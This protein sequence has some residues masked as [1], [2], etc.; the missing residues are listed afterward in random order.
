MRIYDQHL[1]SNHSFDSSAEPAEVCAAAIERGLAGITFT[2]HFDTHPTEWDDCR[3][4]YAAIAAEHARL[5]ERFG[6]RLTVGTGIEVCYQPARMDFILN[7]LG[8]R[9]F[10]L[11]ILSVHWTPC[12][13]IHRK[14][15][16]QG[17]SPEQ[18]TRQYLE[19]VLNAVRYCAQLKKNNASP[20]HVLGHLDFVKR[21]THRWWA[22]NRIEDCTDQVDDI[23][24]YCLKADLIPEI[25]TSTFRKDLGEPMPAAWVTRRYKELGGVCMSLGSD[26]HRPAEVGSHFNEAAQI[27][28]D[29]GLQG[30]A[31]F[32]AG[33][34]TIIPPRGA[35][36]SR[37]P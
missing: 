14:K 27:V 28:A 5:R 36:P 30:Q 8:H 16:W 26:A 33:S 25:N 34:R 9:F 3:F 35:E 4:D 29:A 24:R 21:Y 1:H 32:A 15:S 6:Q 7:Y 20:F 10:D 23:L 2:E 13:P 18:G 31:V 19:T 17:L 37:S 22:E 11:V 12:G